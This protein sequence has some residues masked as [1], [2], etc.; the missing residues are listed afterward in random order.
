M[1]IA[2]LGLAFFRGAG[3]TES[4]VFFPF[5]VAALPLL[6]AVLAVLRR[7][8]SR[9]SPFDGDRRHVYD[10]L[11]ARGWTARQ[12]AS[13]CYGVTSGLVILGWLSLRMNYREALGF[14]ALILTG[15]LG[16]AVGMG[17]L[18]AHEGPPKKPSA[19][20]IRTHEDAGLRLTAPDSN[21]VREDGARRAAV[22]LFRR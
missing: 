6:D 22:A 7:V 15:L 16:A 5:L 14:T 11:L 2:F 13:T 8:G 3:A 9:V 10:L 20:S 18:R 21:G 12:V 17:S 19:P 1:V 4:S